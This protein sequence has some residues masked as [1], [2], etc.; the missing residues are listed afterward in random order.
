MRVQNKINFY[1]GPFEGG[2]FRVSRPPHCQKQNLS[3]IIPLLSGCPSSLKLASQVTEGY[4]IQESPTGVNIWYWLL[5]NDA[6]FVGFFGFSSYHPVPF[7]GSFSFTYPLNIDIL[8]SSVLGHFLTLPWQFH[9]LHDFSYHWY[10]DDFKI[11]SLNL[12]PLLQISISNYPLDIFCWKSSNIF[13]SKWTC[14]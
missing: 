5:S 2:P 10:I 9:L 11:C 14:L 1:A 6:I 3:F 12:F 13:V 7:Y 8:Q 4:C